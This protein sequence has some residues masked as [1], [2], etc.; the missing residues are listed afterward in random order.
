[1]PHREGQYVHTK[2]REVIPGI[3]MQVGMSLHS[4]SVFEGPNGWQECPPE[5][6]TTKLETPDT[7]VRWVATPQKRF[8]RLD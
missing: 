7:Q 6:L 8:V 1:M 5:R 3:P 2:T 4:C